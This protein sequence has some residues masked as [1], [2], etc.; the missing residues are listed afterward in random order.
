ML[1][2]PPAELRQGGGWNATLSCC[3]A[4]GGASGEGGVSLAHPLAPGATIYLQWRL[5]V[6]QTG[7]FKFYVI[8]E[9]L[10]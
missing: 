10:P 5:A 7:T 2:G 1:E 6:Q 4:G 8:I 9:A 3:Q